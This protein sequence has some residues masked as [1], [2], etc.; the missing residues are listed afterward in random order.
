MATRLDETVAR[1]LHETLRVV[2]DRIGADAARAEPVKYTINA[3]YRV[4]PFVIRMNASPATAER[5]VSH[6]TALA[7]VD[8]PTIRLADVGPQP[9]VA[10]GWAATVWL[11]VPTTGRT[12]EPVDLAGPVRTIHR[13]ETLDADLPPW[14]PVAKARRRIDRA[15]G[16]DWMRPWCRDEVGL[17]LDDLV[18]AL[19]ERCDAVER[20]LA[21][22]A[23]HLPAGVLHGDVHTGNLLLATSG[24]A[25]LCDLDS[26]C[27]GPREWDL[28]PPAHGTERMGR[29]RA[30]YAAFADAYGF[31]VT[32]WPGWPALRA[33]RDLQMATST[34]GAFD[35]RAD[36]A[37]QLAHRVRTL[38]AGDDD[39]VWTRYT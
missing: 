31:D 6:A 35:G 13:L 30:A 17:D 14:E 37:Q 28:T 29:P 1:R 21:D 25:L 19:R 24:E 34:F 15:V 10:G 4:P 12:P 2:C 7:A 36:V 33:V 18:A 38:L 32:A 9:I 16:A 39:A 22:V 8:A 3:V 23:W 20:A 11:D 26:V 5:T 27:A